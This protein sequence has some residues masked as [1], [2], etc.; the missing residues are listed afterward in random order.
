MILGFFPPIVFAKRQLLAVVVSVAVSIILPLLLGD[1]NKASAFIPTT[2]T[3]TRFLCRV[4]DDSQKNSPAGGVHR[5]AAAKSNDD[6][7]SSASSKDSTKSPDPLTKA[8]W[9]AV[10]AF[11][12]VFGSSTKDDKSSSSAAIDYNKPPTSLE[13]TIRRIQ[14]DNDREY[15]L[16]GQIDKLI[17]ATDC[18]F[19]DPFVSFQ[20]RERFVENLQNLGSFVTKYSAK[21][22]PLLDN[23]N[24][25][26]NQ[27]VVQEKNVVVE[28]RF[29]VKLELNLPWKPVLAWPW[30][31]RCEID[32]DTYLIV[33]HQEKWDVEAWEGVKQIFRR[34]PT[35]Q[36]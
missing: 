32:P 16:S 5:F 18:T 12:K 23:N 10:E 15:F 21:P 34:K 6:D 29:M 20:G 2:T 13:E 33:L 4:D 30:G 19:A 26:N 1:H 9:Y 22:L 24:K 31:V 27:V 17:Y 3:T 11:G 36:V 7:S 35:V 28:T 8:S 14:L 25:N